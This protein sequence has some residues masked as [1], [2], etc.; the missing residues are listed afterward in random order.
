[1]PLESH[2]CCWPRASSPA[3]PTPELPADRDQPLIFY[4][5][6]DL[7]S[8]AVEAA[9]RAISAGY[10]DVA[11]MPDG[12]QVWLSAELQTSRSEAG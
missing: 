4:C 6:S 2:C 10:S 9:R 1:M 5:Y 3:R 12:I 11:V 8:A 7:C